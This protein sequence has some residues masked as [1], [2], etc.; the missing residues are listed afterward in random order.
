[1]PRWPLTIA[2]CG[3]T[4]AYSRHVRRRE[5]I[6]DACREAMKQ[7]RRSDP[8][9]RAHHDAAQI[10]GRQ[11]RAAH[12]AEYHHLYAAALKAARERHG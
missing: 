4:A 3:T 7:Y 9:R 2:A 5:S 11:L 8:N 6:D 12:M 10:A 1:M